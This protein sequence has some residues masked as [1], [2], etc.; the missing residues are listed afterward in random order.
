M[1]LVA[2]HYPLAVI[3]GGERLQSWVGAT[4]GIAAVLNGHLHWRLGSTLHAFHTPPPPAAQ[5]RVAE[6]E[7]GDWKIS[8]AWR[9]LALDAGGAGSAG[10]A[11]VLSF[12]DFR[13][14]AT[15]PGGMVVMGTSP[16]DGRY[17]STAPAAG[18]PR[19]HVRALVFPPKGAQPQSL[20][21]WAVAL[22]AG[23]EVAR[24]AMARVGAEAGQGSGGAVWTSPVLPPTAGAFAGSPFPLEA[25]ARRCPATGGV[26]HVRVEASCEGAP[27]CG[28]AHEWPILFDQASWPLPLNNTRLV[29]TVPCVREEN[30]TSH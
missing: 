27:R 26:L 1:R 22:C 16:P 17:S 24:V 8:R 14:D 4:H 23:T 3:I 21:V 19:A 5:R 15:S 13:Y 25:F 29:R 10:S 2:T 18:A 28:D 30:A 12:R 9:L 11:P 20:R 7:A 6:L